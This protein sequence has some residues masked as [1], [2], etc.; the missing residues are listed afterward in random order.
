[1]T[2]IGAI[3]AGSGIIIEERSGQPFALDR[4]GW[5]HF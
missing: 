4:T 1:V 2:Q 3:A 5:D